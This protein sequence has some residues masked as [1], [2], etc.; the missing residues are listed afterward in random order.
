MANNLKRMQLTSFV[1]YKGD[2]YQLS[3]QLHKKTNPKVYKRIQFIYRKQ[4]SS[5]FPTKNSI[6]NVNQNKI[7]FM[8]YIKICLYLATPILHYTNI[9]YHTLHL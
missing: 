8:F 1:L 6:K 4:Y 3:I 7:F 2:Q 9:L 5:F